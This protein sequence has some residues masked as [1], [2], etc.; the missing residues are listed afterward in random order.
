M[1]RRVREEKER[2]RKAEE[3]AAAWELRLKTQRAEEIKE[4]QMRDRLIQ[5]QQLLNQQQRQQFRD[6]PINLDQQRNL[7]P[8]RPISPI[9]NDFSRQ[10]H[11]IPDDAFRNRGRGNHVSNGGGER[12][13][14]IKIES[15]PHLEN[16]VK[17]PPASVKSPPTS[18]RSVPINSVASRSGH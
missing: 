7:P 1:E 17:S 18:V 16:N 3:E 2:A 6:V 15:R 14:P 9:M 12:I 11:P 8:P 5:E 10:P 13:I 4:Q